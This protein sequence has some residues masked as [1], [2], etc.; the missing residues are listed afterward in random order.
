VTAR[1]AVRYRKPVPINRGLLVR[2]DLERADERQLH[3]TGELL[4]GGTVLA[5]ARGMFVSVP[6]EHFLQ[7]AEGRAARDAWQARLSESS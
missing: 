4:D 6:F 5:D 7:T 2:A 3:V 1:L